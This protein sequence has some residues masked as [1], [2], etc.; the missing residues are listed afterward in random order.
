[1]TNVR[2]R[3]RPL[4]GGIGITPSTGAGAYGTLTGV[5]RRTEDRK[6]VLV[7]NVH[8]VSTRDY[9][10]EGA[11]SI[12]QW[13]PDESNTETDKVG[14]LYANTSS[15]EA[16]SWLPVTEGGTNLGD[17]A[18]LLLA[19]NVPAEFAIHH[20]THG[21]RP[22]VAPSVP[23][24][25]DMYLTMLGANTGETRVRVTAVGLPKT[26]TIKG[27][28]D[29]TTDD[30]TD[31]RFSNVTVVYRFQTPGAS[32]DSGAPLVWQDDDGNYRMCCINFA[33]TIDPRRSFYKRL[34][35]PCI[36]GRISSRH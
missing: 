21:K 4:V 13:E 34:Y 31:Y 5:A 3:H 18:A 8:V 15:G 35:H 19:E 33:K 36:R 10:L 7:T 11:E 14:T 25:E 24:Q 32:G 27:P 1:M 23:P 20:P 2:S 30:D 6:K 17:L 12:Y 9:E 26:V 29:T 22:I 28:D 16:D